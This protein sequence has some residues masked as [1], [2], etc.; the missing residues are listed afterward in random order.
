MGQQQLLLLVVGLIIV[1]V[2]VVVGINQFTEA[3]ESAGI[4]N[5][6]AAQ[7]HL[8][9]SALRHYMKPAS[10]GGGEGSF[11]GTGAVG[12][13]AWVIPLQLINVGPYAV[14]AAVTAAT[15]TLTTTVGTKIVSTV[16]TGTPSS[17]V[18]SVN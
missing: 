5:V 7:Q 11:D 6:I 1:A 14:S 13:S 17:V 12:G 15:V 16:V 10:F 9:G 8:G 4:D 2:A 18:T 3:T